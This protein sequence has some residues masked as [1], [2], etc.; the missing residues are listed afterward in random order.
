MSCVPH[1]CPCGY[2]TDPKRRCKCTPNQVE[3]YL[4]RISGPLIDRI[5]IHVDVPAVPFAELTSK[6]DGTD[7]AAMRGQVI[8]ARARQT[9]RLADLDILTN[10]QM[11]S[12]QLR[13][14]CQLD[15]S[16]VDLIKQAVYELGLSARAHDKVLRISRTIADIEEAESIEAHHIA[17]AIQY[18]R[19]DR[20]L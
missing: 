15:D 19:L 3:R 17:E 5:D 6:R 16:G 8:T 2:V 11:S 13:E 7:S 4:S 18:R 10:S 12:R 9:E 14:F 20:K 1:G